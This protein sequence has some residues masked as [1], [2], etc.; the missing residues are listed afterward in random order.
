[1]RRAPAGLRKAIEGAIG[2]RTLIMP[3]RDSTGHQQ[4]VRAIVNRVPIA[5]LP[6]LANLQRADDCVTC[7]VDIAI[8][9]R[10]PDE[11]TADVVADWLDRHLVLKWRSARTR[12]A[13]V[14]RTIYW[15][16][17]R[18]ARNLVL[19]PK[20]RT[21]IRL[22]LRF[23]NAAAV[24]RAGLSDP[25]ALAGLDPAAL[26]EHHV[27]A[28]DLCTAYVAKLTTRVRYPDRAL[29]V[30]AAIDVQGFVVGRRHLERKI[31]RVTLPF[32][33]PRSISVP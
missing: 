26:F 31:E 27:K 25:A 30:L 9:I 13:W 20:S 16:D 2:R 28:V 33:I 6:V 12:K 8:D 24:R 19:Y 4:G 15:S 29:S 1:M 18:R 17:A 23:L 11:P 3:C 10:L 21:M 14:G 22:E 5:A 32:Q 7:R